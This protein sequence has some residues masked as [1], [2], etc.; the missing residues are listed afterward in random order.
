MGQLDVGAEGPM[1]W[2]D[3]KKVADYVRSHGITQLIAVFARAAE[4]EGLSLLWGDEVGGANTNTNTNTRM[5]T[6]PLLDLLS[7]P[8]PV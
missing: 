3:A 6:F 8:L 2:A 7:L 1:D 5:P 4:F